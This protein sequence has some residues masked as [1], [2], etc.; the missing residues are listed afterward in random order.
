MYNPDNDDN[1]RR[2]VD[3]ANPPPVGTTVASVLP[4]RWQRMNSMTWRRRTSSCSTPTTVK[5]TLR[6]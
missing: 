3:S 1:R 2:I 4:V 5:N 6:S